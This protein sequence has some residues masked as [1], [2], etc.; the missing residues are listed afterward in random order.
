MLLAVLI[1][2]GVRTDQNDPDKNNIHEI[3][4]L[5]KQ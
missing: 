3:A 5:R 4:Y 1:E 2:R